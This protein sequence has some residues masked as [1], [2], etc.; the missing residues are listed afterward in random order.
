[1]A[2]RINKLINFID[3]YKVVCD[4][5]TDHGITAIRVYEEKK[6]KNVIATDISKNSLQK[7]IDKIEDNSY[8][9]KTVVTDGIKDLKKYK[10]EQIIISGMGGFLITK[11]LDEGKEVA[12]NAEKLVLQANNSLA[13]LRRYLLQHGYEII[14]EVLAM[15]DNIFYDIIVA[16]YTDSKPIYYSK[17]YFYEYGKLIIEKNDPLL[18]D[19]INKNI[20]ISMN[21]K[22]QI[23]DTNTVS[24]KRR[25]SE[26]NQELKILEDVLKCL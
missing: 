23:K 6:P 1:M 26:I 20:D 24:S 15:D 9:I 19:K 7:L 5:G 17:E 13:H 3:E 22:N 16:R 14:D 8:E 18:K 2:D 10:P 4:I 25:I 11:I 12:H 21:I